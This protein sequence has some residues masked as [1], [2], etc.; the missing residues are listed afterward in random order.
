MA[1]KRVIAH[2]MNEQEE[3]AALRKMTNVQRTE[4]YVLGEIDEADIPALRQKGLVIQVLEEQ[5]RAE[6]PGKGVEPIPGTVLRRSREAPSAKAPEPTIDR[7]KPNFYLIQLKGP[8]LEE[9]RRQLRQLRVQLL[10]YVPRDNYTARLTPRQVDAV[11]A[12]PFVNAIRLYGPEDTG[13]VSAKEVEEV[14]PPSTTPSLGVK[15]VTFDVRLHR[16]RDLPK[17]LKWLEKRKVNIAG[18][19]GRKIRLYLLEG[20]PLAD[21]I[22][23]LPEV[24]VMEE[25]VPPKLHNDVARVLLGIDRPAHPNPT[26]DIPQTGEGQIVAVADTGLDARHPDFQGRIAGVVAWGRP[27]DPSDPHGHGTHVAGSVLG[28]GSASGGHIRGTAPK[29]KL[30]F[31]S[32]LDANGELGGLPLNLGDLFEEAYWAGARIHNNSWGAATES[33]YTANSIEVDEFVAKRRDI[34][35]VISA[36]NQGQAAQ[37]RHSLPGFVDW[38]SIGSPASAKN[39]LT[40]GASRSS[41]T[42]G[43]YATL[44]YR[45]A[46]PGEFPDPPIANEKISG[47]PEGL[48]A[49]SSRGPCDDRRIKPDVVAP[50]TDII[51]TK[52]SL[53]P[54]RNFWGPYPGSGH[55]AFMGGTSMAAPL[56]SGCAA[57]VREYYVKKH[58]HEPSAALLKATLINGTRWL[59]APDAIADH[60]YLPNYHQGFG[61]IHM[62]WTIPNPAEPTLK[63]E[64]QDTW[65]QKRLQFTRSGQRIRFQFSISG[66]ARLRICLTWTDLPARALQNNLNLFV[67]HLPSGQKWIGNENLPMGLKIPDPDNNVEVV[68]LDNPPAGNYLIQISA[69]NLLK[70]PQD[71]ALVV[72]G[73]LT[74]SLTIIS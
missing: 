26:A 41:R 47:N 30:F 4:S 48:A 45:L 53:A 27:N 54:L 60:P 9:W 40:V 59:T 68:R 67:Q 44:T 38:L 3:S 11:S 62:P 69:T 57:L 23:A 55:Y 22:A 37:R 35:I 12:L 64:F 25:Y 49:F 24:A 31:Q 8:L 36:G 13:P 21:E 51:S 15:M 34:L 7:S 56:V 52:S 43:G 61:C 5:P 63:L 58:K 72:T 10:E 74:S 70:G 18:A 42:E 2:F 66:G 32:L 46:W 71:F 6:T 17:V 19:T 33:M 20:S 39:A 29:A 73:E 14:E 50:G 16:E 28:D 65:K 1:K